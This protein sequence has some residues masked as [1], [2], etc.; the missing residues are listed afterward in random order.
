MFLHE[1]R[2]WIRPDGRALLLDF[3]APR[4]RAATDGGRV[5]SAGDD[6]PP[7]TP[8]ALLA[9]VGQVALR[10]RPTEGGASSFRPVPLAAARLI[11][12]C[13]TFV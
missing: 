7:A 8:V 13:G 11:A 3:A 5:R 1:N 12:S 6:G 4:T 9:R 10:R 2:V